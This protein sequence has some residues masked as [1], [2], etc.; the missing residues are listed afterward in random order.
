MKKKEYRI[1]LVEDEPSDAN[2]TLH[3]LRASVSPRFEITWV[4]SLAEAKNQLIKNPPEI[5]ILDLSLPDSNGIETIINGRLAAKSLPIIVLTGQDD[6]D[7]ALKT[8]D[9]GAQDYIVKGQFDTDD[10]VRAIRYSI[11]RAKLEQKLLESEQFAIS[12]IDAL[13]ALICVVDETCKIIT[14]NK[15]WKEFYNEL[16]S[17]PLN[18]FIGYNYFEIFASTNGANSPEA[19]S[20]EIGIASVINKESSFFAHEY[21]FKTKKFDLWFNVRVTKFPGNYNHFVIAHENVTERKIAEIEREQFFKFFNSSTD[22]MVI[23]DP[24]GCFKKINNACLNVLGYTEK[25]LLSKPFIEFVHPDDKQSTLN[26]MERQIKI[27]YTL[28]FENRYVCSDGSYKFLSWHANYIHN[29][30]ITYASGRDI[31]ERKHLEEALKES[32]EK[33]KA[34]FDIIDVGIT[35]TDNDGNII[36]CN[37][38]SEK[39][40]S[41]TIQEHLERNYDSKKWKIINPDFTEMLIADYPMVRAIKEKKPISNVEMGIVKNESEITWIIVNAFPLSL[42]NYGLVVSYIDITELKNINYQLSTLNSTKDKFFSIIAHDLK[43]PIGTL[44]SFLNFLADKNNTL[45]REDLREDLLILQNSSKTIFS[46]LENLLTW[47]RSQKG[48]ITYFPSENDTF[49]LIQSNL[50]LFIA[51]AENK[52]IRLIN[53]AQMGLLAYYDIQ[54]IN[55]VFRNL[56]N[57]AIKYTNTGGIV[58]ISTRESEKFIEITIN[59][60]GVGMT[61]FVSNNMFK[62]DVKHF[63]IE[64]TMGEKGTGLGLILCKEFID[65]HRGKIWVESVYGQGSAFTFTLP[66]KCNN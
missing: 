12:T 57:N 39:I 41:V 33:L 53:N 55:T 60:T 42:P 44:H 62:I 14:A 47:A 31:T 3:A 32:E 65:K 50:T 8:L 1:L 45:S 21:E 59:D 17:E 58:T 23:A 63:S 38:A 20:M 51:P 29:E 27:G 61:E 16:F 56:L 19:K 10:L 40:L 24:N 7:F 9:A 15:A 11:N 54:M 49:E 36:D 2:L 26:E 48:E 13:S 37:R 18:S 46:L 30:G 35:I 66:K 34:I 64:G 22:L 4:T 28:D 5:L 52:K 6:S 25:E 43:G